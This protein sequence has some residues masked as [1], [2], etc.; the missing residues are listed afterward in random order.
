MLKKSCL[1]I[2]LDF[3]VFPYIYATLKVIILVNFRYNQNKIAVFFGHGLTDEYTTERNA[4]WFDK[5]RLIM[6]YAKEK[7]MK[8]Y[9]LN[10]LKQLGKKDIILNYTYQGRDI[11]T[12]E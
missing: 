10:D 1:Q 2:Q 12:D 7:R 9:T 6:N 4:I 8:F 3:C 5:F 11:E